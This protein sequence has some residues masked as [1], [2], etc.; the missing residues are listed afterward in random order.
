MNEGE[1]RTIDAYL[2]GE[3][4][5]TVSVRT[6]EN[7]SVIDLKSNGQHTQNPFTISS[8]NANEQTISLTVKALSE[9]RDGTITYIIETD[10]ETR[11][12][13]SQVI[14][15]PPAA[16]DQPAPIGATSPVT[17]IV[18]LALIIAAGYMLYNHLIHGR[19]Q[20]R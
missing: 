2:S 11:T 15:G 1:T 10:E 8:S 5:A 20:R 14:V 7:L 19:S 13:S 18:L 16:T 3:G 9:N 4:T 6:N 17:I 12:F